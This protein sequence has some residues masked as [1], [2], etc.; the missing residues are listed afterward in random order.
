MDGLINKAVLI[1]WIKPLIEK[2][3]EKYKEEYEGATMTIDEFRKKDCG[4]KGQEWVRIYIFDQFPEVDVE[5]GGFVK[6][7][8]NGKKTII[9]RKDAKKWIENNYHRIDWNASI[10]KDFGR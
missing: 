7:P 8:H 1:K 3:F 10:K 9:F 5:N 2:L 6:N 4:G